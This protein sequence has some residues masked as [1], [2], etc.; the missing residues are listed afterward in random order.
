MFKVNKLNIQQV[1]NKMNNI[2]RD[3]ASYED[4]YSGPRNDLRNSNRVI[5]PSYHQQMYQIASHDGFF[6]QA[7]PSQ[8]HA[9]MRVATRIPPTSLRGI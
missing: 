7:L 5:A 9:T 8:Y 2:E 1:N 6:E 4:D 3:S